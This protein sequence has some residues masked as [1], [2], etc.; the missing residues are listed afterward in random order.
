M[1]KHMK[2]YI[3]QNFKGNILYTIYT[4]AFTSFFA[5]S[6]V[7]M[8]FVIDAIVAFNMRDVSTRLLINIVIISCAYFFSYLRNVQKE[9]MIQKSIISMKMDVLKNLETFSYSEYYKRNYTDYSAWLN[10]DIT[11]LEDK[12]FRQFY[13]LIYCICMILS[14]F[15]SLLFYN[16]IFIALSLLT[17]LIIYLI[18]KSFQTKMKER[19]YQVSRNMESSLSNTVQLLKGFNI[20][21]SL[22]KRQLLGKYSF[23]KFKEVQESKVDQTVVMRKLFF[24]L[25]MTQVFG[26]MSIMLASAFL[27][28]HKII[29]VGSVV[30]TTTLS[31]NLYD[32]IVQASTL[33]SEIRSVNPIFE[34]IFPKTKE[35]NLSQENYNQ[36]DF[37]FNENIKLNKLTYTYDNGKSINFPN[38]MFEEGKKYAIVGKS[39][40]GKSTLLNLLSGLYEEYEGDFLIDGI[41]RKEISSVSYREHVSYISQDSYLFNLNLRDNLKLEDAY[42]DDEILSA[43][44]KASFLE[45]L[46]QLKNGLD[47]TIRSGGIN[48]SGGQVQRI[49]IAKS[50]LRLKNLV[51]IDEGTAHLDEHKALEIENF[52]LMNNRLTVIMVTHQLRKEIKGLFNEVYTL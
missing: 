22:N 39:G 38:M 18:S 44:N 31:G 33:L 13:E 25:Q 45:D 36:L 51:I 52:L 17:A 40:S 5:L 41:Q 48:F 27:A 6:T 30:S 8:T 46:T 35:N 21:Y 28:I 43:L 20:F 10:T 29:P 26:E 42:T 15:F 24:S 19:S 4:L 9:R 7:T 37:S 14:S 16:I 32:T 3:K 49:T 11:L 1:N 23:S 2:K 34:K 50:F 12:A 47:T